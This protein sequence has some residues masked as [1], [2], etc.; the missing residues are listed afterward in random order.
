VNVLACRRRLDAQILE[1]VAVLGVVVGPGGSV[2]LPPADLFDPLGMVGQRLAGLV[3]LMI[4]VP[5]SIRVL[6]QPQATERVVEPPVDGAPP[7]PI[8]GNFEGP[9]HVRV[10]VEQLVDGAQEGGKVAF[11]PR[12]LDLFRPFGDHGLDLDIRDVS[13]SA[14]AVVVQ[15]G[16]EDGVGIR[17]SLDAILQ[18]GLIQNRRHALGAEAALVE[19]TG[20]NLLP[21]PLRIA[22]A[23]LIAIECVDGPSLED[24]AALLVGLELD[25][26]AVAKAQLLGDLG[27]LVVP[28]DGGD[29]AHRQ[30]RLNLLHPEQLADQV[31]GVG[32][33][34]DGGA[35]RCRAVWM[36]P[37][38]ERTE[39]EA[40]VGLALAAAVA[41]E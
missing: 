3:V 38:G 18:P 28:D 22:L 31:P 7:G 39:V 26:V 24:L 32:R 36:Q 1:L 10:A 27:A 29:L 13:A 23:L 2:A 34:P 17:E 19:Q 21:D 25:P 5:V 15:I 11:D 6:G 33:C 16:V 35:L 37:Q 4:D 12:L 9:Q 20:L 40:D 8:G 30:V 41:A 14:F